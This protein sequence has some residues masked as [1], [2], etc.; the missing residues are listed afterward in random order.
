MKRGKGIGRVYKLQNSY[1]NVKFEVSTVSTDP[2]KS[3]QLETRFWFEKDS[4]LDTKKELE[5]IFRSCKQTLFFEG[6][7]WYDVDKLIFIKD[8][9]QDVT[10]SAAKTFAL[11]EFTL[12][13]TVKFDNDIQVSIAST[14][15]TDILYKKVF[16]ERTNLTKSKR[17]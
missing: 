4:D 9:P 8:I 17:D 3:L 12:F 14:K 6:G 1:S 15:L 11:F 13:P 2:L 10:T 5:Q 16:S 7:D